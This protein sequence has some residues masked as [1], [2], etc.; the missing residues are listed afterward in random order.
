MEWWKKLPEWLRWILCWPLIMI[1]AAITQI[2]GVILGGLAVDRIWISKEIG[3]MLVPIIGSLFALP[4]FFFAIQH[5]VPRKQHYVVLIWCLFDLLA[6]AS[7]AIMVYFDF[8]NDADELWWT[9][10]DLAWGLI[11]LTIGVYYFLKIRSGHDVLD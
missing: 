1:A 11:G 2:I 5:L 7:A 4:I 9:I 3:E 6:T 8:V 10:R